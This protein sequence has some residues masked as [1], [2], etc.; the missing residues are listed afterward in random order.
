MNGHAMATTPREITVRVRLDSAPIAAALQH[1]AEL[2]AAQTGHSFETARDS[3]EAVIAAF[4]GTRS[5]R[6]VRLERRAHRRAIRNRY[7][8]R[9]A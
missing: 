7:R 1:A 8:R 4:G 2:L 5:P 6:A 3:I 9:A